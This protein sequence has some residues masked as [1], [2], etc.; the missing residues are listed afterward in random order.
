MDIYDK[1]E[2][3]FKD[4]NDL[5]TKPEWAND[6]LTE[7]KDIK[8]LLQ[9]LSTN[10]KQQIHSKQTNIDRD[11]YTFVNLF[12]SKMKPDTDNGIYPEVVYN[13]TRLGVNFKG[14]LYNK[15]TS[16]TIGREDAFKIYH[17]LYDTKFDLDT[18]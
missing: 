13:G 12:R 6:I 7:L 18:I 15:T 2:N 14:L 9:E 3:I 5:S 8:S 16:E 17:Y 4:D 1:I 11:Y 10:S